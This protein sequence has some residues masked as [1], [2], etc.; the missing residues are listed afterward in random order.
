MKKLLKYITGFV[1][2][3]IGILVLSNKKNKKVNEIKDKIKDVDREL[4]KAKKDL[5]TLTINKQEQSDD[6][7]SGS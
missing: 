7:V 5:A 3:V 2:F 1:S 6:W 4:K